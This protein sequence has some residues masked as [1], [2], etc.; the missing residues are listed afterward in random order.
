MQVTIKIKSGADHRD[1]VTKNDIQKNIDVIETI[2]S[3]GF[4]KPEAIVSLNDTKSILVAIQ[5]E[6]D[7]FSEP[8]SA[9]S[10]I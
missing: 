8:Q 7:D 1:T 5:K 10:F 6:L 2:L 4:L 3:D 9:H